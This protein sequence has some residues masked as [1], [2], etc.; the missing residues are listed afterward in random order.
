VHQ[1]A[2]RLDRLEQLAARQDGEQRAYGSSA[3][4]C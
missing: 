1:L 2:D 3:A 4:S